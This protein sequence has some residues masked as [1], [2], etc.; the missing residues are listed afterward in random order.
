MVLRRLTLET[1]MVKPAT[2][3][4]SPS[5]LPPTGHGPEPVLPSARLLV[6]V[7]LTRLIG[8][9][10]WRARPPPL[11]P[12]L[13]EKVELRTLSAPPLIEAA[14]PPPVTPLASMAVLPVNNMPVR[15]V[16]EA[17]PSASK[18]PPND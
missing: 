12:V 6:T 5:T 14:P 3:P 8:P 1:G 4:P 13:P 17:G 2:P 15:F 11:V 10:P 18:P 9:A 7:T 16:V